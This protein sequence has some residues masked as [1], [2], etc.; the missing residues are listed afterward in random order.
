MPRFSY[1]VKDREANLISGAIEARDKFFVKRELKSKNLTIISIIEEKDKK[2]EVVFS[3]GRGKKIKPMDLVVFSRQ[4]AT[5]ID[6]GI[7]LVSGLNI[8]QE[9][10]TNLYLKKLVGN[11]KSDIEA[12]NSLSSSFA[13]YPEAFPE[14]FI[15]M[16]EAGESSGSLNEILERLADYL[17]KTEN[18]R[19]KVRSSLSYP[20]LVVG[21]AILIV[22]F[23]MLKVVP[24]FKKIFESLGG[25]LPLPTMILI[26]TSDLSVRLFPFLAPLLILLYI[27]IIRYIRTKEGRFKFDQLKLSLPIFG[28]LFSKVAIS[29]FTR[30][31]ATLQSGGVNILEAFVVTGKVCGNKVIERATE[32]VKV[33]LQAGESIS[34]PMAKTGK[35][36]IFVVKMIGVGERTGELEKMLIKVSDYYENQVTE[37]LNGLSSMVEPI[38]IVFLGTVIGFIVLAMF[39]PIFKL[40]QMISG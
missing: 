26:K 29:R 15:N 36:P 31:L 4:L 22:A 7:S 1:V 25:A 17:E 10:V 23:L 32:Q 3:G 40:T 38:I 11:I 6:S 19:R 12:G 5:L 35:F 30:T 14:I 28:E 24:T 20:I 2:R 18:I 34:E 21:M 27:G 37:T 33:E 13:K 39:L 16:I 8:L 9:Q